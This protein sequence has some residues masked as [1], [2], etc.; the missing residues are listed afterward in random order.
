M[1]FASYAVGQAYELGQGVEKDLSSAHNFYA[2][3]LKGLEK[4]FTKNHDD[5]ISYKIGMMYLNG[6]G[7]D[8]DLECAE[9]ICCSRR[10]PITIKHN[11][12]SVSSIRATAK[13]SSKG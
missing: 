1:P 4:V 3:A 9:N 5:N 8:I 6:N 13:R 7:T 10:T 2:E 12:C 11:I